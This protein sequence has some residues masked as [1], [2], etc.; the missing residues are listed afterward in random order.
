MV[1]SIPIKYKYHEPP[2]PPGYE[3]NSITT[4]LLGEALALS[5]LQR[6]ICHLTKKQMKKQQIQIIFE[7]TYLTHIH[8]PNRYN[9]FRSE[10]T[11]T[12]NHEMQFSV[13]PRNPPFFSKVL[14]LRRGYSRYILIPANILNI[15]R[16][17]YLLACVIL[18]EQQIKWYIKLWKCLLSELSRTIP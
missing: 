15:C 8:D 3:L 17:I 10:W 11:W 1:S 16:K 4:V 9:H 7:Q 18:F 12:L 5:N 2:Y 13:I 6:L 14:L